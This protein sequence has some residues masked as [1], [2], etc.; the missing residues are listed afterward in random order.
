MTNGRETTWNGLGIDV[1]GSKNVQEAIVRAGLDYTVEK[2]AIKT[3]NGVKIPDRYA[4]VRTRDKK[5]YDIVSDRYQVIQN[6]DAFDFVNNISPDLEF[7]KAGETK[8]GIVW[9]IGELPE[10]DILGD[11]FKPSV[12]FQNSFS[13]KSKI[14][15]AIC[16]I[17]LACQNQ[18][19]FAFRKANNTVK[20]LHL[21]DVE[22]KMREGNE[23]LKANAE[24]M[25]EI[26]TQAEKYARVRL[27]RSQLDQVIDNMFPVQEEMNSY[28]KFKMEESRER[29]KRAYNSDDN[30]N[31]RG[32][33]WGLFNAYSDF[34][35]HKEPGGK[36]KTKHENYFIRT[37]FNPMLI[38]MAMR[39]KVQVK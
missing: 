7:V 26:R 29:F 18:F 31:F 15:A 19:N 35:T 36:S 12:L 30:G 23:V 27:S 14:S 33:A 39:A 3:E 1:R 24:F 21:G 10:V 22:G 9:I 11:S 4:T 13:G 37:T 8:S 28:A 34:I 6:M 32:T 17:R 20:I 16:P 2:Q 5:I 38:P 25:E